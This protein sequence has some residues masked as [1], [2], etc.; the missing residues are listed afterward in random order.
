MSK[1]IYI[2]LLVIIVPVLYLF[3]S[4]LISLTW[5][6]VVPDVFSGA[7]AHGTLPATIT[8]TQAFKL[9][10]LLTMLGVASRTNGGKD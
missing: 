5:W 9:S 2:V 8:L 4:W 3:V 6:W 1:A 10:L 7:V